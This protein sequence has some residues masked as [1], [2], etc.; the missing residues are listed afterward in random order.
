MV[1]STDSLRFQEG[2]YNIPLI[3]LELEMAF[4]IGAIDHLLR[5]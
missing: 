5:N 2:A 4:N 3:E 1:I